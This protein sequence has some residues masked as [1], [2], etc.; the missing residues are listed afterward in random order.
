MPTSFIDYQGK[1][2]LFIDYSGLKKKEEMLDT[3]Y[4]AVELANQ[5]SERLR[6]LID[7]T[8]SSGSQEWMEESKKQGKEMREKAEKTAIVGVKGVK[9]VLLMGYNTVVGGRVK[10]FSTKESAL[11]YLNGD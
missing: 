10:P 1:K 3:L 7:I 4:Q 6:T 11:A 9:K 2:I 8:D 5:S